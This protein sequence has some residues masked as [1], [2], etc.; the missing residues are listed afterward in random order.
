MKVYYIH[1]NP[2]EKN[3]VDNFWPRHT[4]IYF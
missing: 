4:C 2:F 3:A 1:K